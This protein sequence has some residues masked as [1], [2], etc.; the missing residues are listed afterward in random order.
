MISSIGF[1]YFFE[2]VVIIDNQ[3]LWPHKNEAVRKVAYA[4]ILRV[5]L[6]MMKR[7][8]SEQHGSLALAGAYEIVEPSTKNA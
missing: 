7:I 8:N 1:R 3:P 6:K 2:N 5:Y 4:N